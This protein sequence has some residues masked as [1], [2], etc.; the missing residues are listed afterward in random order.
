M[1]PLDVVL[2]PDASNPNSTRQ[3]KALMTTSTISTTASMKRD[4]DN[5][6]GRSIVG[7]PVG[8]LSG[9]AVGGRDLTSV[10]LYL[11]CVDS[12]SYVGTFAHSF[13]FCFD[14]MS[15]VGICGKATFCGNLTDTMG[16]M[17]SSSFLSLLMSL[18]E[19]FLI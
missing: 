8:Q 11:F 16:A 10:C 7:A 6:S 4:D 13:L 12:M 14:R 5:D 19:S 18:M 1:Q 15:S 2:L 17:D 9:L 3:F